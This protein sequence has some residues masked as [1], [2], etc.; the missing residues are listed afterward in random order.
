MHG[1][2]KPTLFTLDKRWRRP[3][4]CFVDPC[5]IIIINAMLL[6]NVFLSVWFVTLLDTNTCVWLYIHKYFVDK[7]PKMHCVNKVFYITK[8]AVMFICF[9]YSVPMSRLSVHDSPQS[10]HDETHEEAHGR[11][12]LHLHRLP[13][14]IFPVVLVKNTHWRCTSAIWTVHV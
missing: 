11:E 8:L 5:Y 14:W 3:F 12:A 1:I 10:G 6:L 9:C 7:P 2:K 4:Y 13:A